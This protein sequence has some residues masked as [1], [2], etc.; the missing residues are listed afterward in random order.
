MES[1]VSNLGFVMKL[2][3]NEDSVFIQGRSAKFTVETDDEKLPF[4]LKG[5]FGEVHPQVLDNFELEYPTIMFEI[6][7][8]E[9]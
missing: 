1:I 2:E 7:F 5:Y 4:T 8:M 9:K 3:D 6:E